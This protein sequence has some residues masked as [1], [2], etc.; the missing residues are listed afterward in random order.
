MSRKNMI[1]LGA[2][3]KKSMCSYGLTTIK[4]AHEMAISILLMTQ[5]LR[6]GHRFLTFG[7]V[8][9]GI[10][11]L[12]SLLYLLI[13]RRQISRILIGFHRFTI[14]GSAA[15]TGHKTKCK[16]GENQNQ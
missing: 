15:A 10:K 5:F 7:R 1:F 9:I 4:S 11:G 12:M 8:N 6:R 2:K 3:S 14:Y 13:S 16:N